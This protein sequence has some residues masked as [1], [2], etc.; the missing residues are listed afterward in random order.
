MS[1]TAPPEVVYSDIDIGFAKAFDS[2]VALKGLVILR[3]LSCGAGT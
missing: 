2:V 3:R 1:L